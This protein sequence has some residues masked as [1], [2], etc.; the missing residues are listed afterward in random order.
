MN[1]ISVTLPAKSSCEITIV[2][3]LT[4]YPANIV[5]TSINANYPTFSQAQQIKDYLILSPYSY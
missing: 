3:S 4:Q 1:K 2:E 5:N